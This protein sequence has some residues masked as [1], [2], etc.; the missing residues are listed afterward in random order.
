MTGSRILF[1]TPRFPYPLI[2]G[3]RIKSYHM[4]L[5]LARHHEV[6]LVT[7]AKGDQAAPENVQAIER[8]GVT[9]HPVPFHPLRAGLKSIETLYTDRPLEIAF[10]TQPE[11]QARVDELTRQMKFDVGIAFFMRTAEYLRKK[12]FRKILV[13]ED[14][15][16]LYQLRSYE[17]S[18]NMLQQLIRWWEVR[19]LRRYEPDVVRHFDTTTFVT[20]T[21]IEAMRKGNPSAEYRLLTNGVDLDEFAFLPE[22]DKRDGVLFFGK[23]D[24]WAN[25]MMVTRIAEKIRPLIQRGVPRTQFRIVGARPGELEQ[26]FAAADFS[27]FADVPDIR[28][29][30]N[31]SAVFLHPHRGASGIQNKVLQAM[32][33]GCPVVTTP[34]GVQG[35]EAVHGEH[36]LIGESDAELA[37][38]CVALLEDPALRERLA[39]N[40]RTMIARTHSWDL[41]YEQL[42]E[43]LTAADAD[44]P[45]RAH[46]PS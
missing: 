45:N 28:E 29:Y 16:E 22:Q 13:A 26:R 20:N 10:Y 34:T 3:D 39:R 18:N 12:S 31:S 44:I 42:D 43:I 24:V 30:V 36:A 33:M 27:F 23:L 7:F 41:V 25:S 4:L 6:H 19:K 17:S 2:G 32:S 1:C 35:I 15:R 8:L 46:S 5:H 11:F 14:C 21:D 9:V 38:H 40:A 37:Q